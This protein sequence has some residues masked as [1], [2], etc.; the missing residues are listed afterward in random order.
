MKPSIPSS[1]INCCGLLSTLAVLLALSGTVQL[2]DLRRLA[3]RAV[4]ALLFCF[5]AGAI[6]PAASRCARS[7]RN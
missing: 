5:A 3:V 2:A 7:L 1:S 4:M 6:E